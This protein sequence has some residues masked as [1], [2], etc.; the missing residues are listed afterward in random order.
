[1][2]KKIY[3]QILNNFFYKKPVAFYNLMHQ[4]VLEINVY[5]NAVK[6][7]I[8]SKLLHSNFPTT[9]YVSVYRKIVKGTTAKEMLLQDLTVNNKN[10]KFSKQI[11]TELPKDRL[12]VIL[13]EIFLKEDYYFETETPEPI[14]LDCGAN[15]G[16]AVYY[17]KLKFPQSKIIAFEPIERF[18]NIINN[19]LALNKWN[20][21]EVIPAAVGNAKDTLT[22]YESAK[23]P[24]GGSLTPRKVGQDNTLNEIKVPVVR[25]RDY[26][27]TNIDF[28][29]LDTEGNE[30]VILEDIKDLLGNVKSLFIE[31]HEGNGLT[32]DRLIKILAIL[33]SAGY[34]VLI[35]QNFSANYYNNKRAW[36]QIADRKSLCIWAKR[37]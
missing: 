3:T 27:T 7:A 13:N 16:M 36:Q 18:C 30:D 5:N 37:I 17:F 1:M 15:V 11:F 34:T 29:K 23:D 20:N 25:L 6:N 22:F 28:L 4:S 9:H 2:F 8:A 35:N 12:W 21:V 32:S 19:T 14:I 24:L 26:I 10:I 33:H 31:Y